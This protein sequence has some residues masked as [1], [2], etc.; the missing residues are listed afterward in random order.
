MIHRT[1][2]RGKKL[3]KGASRWDSGYIQPTGKWQKRL[4]SK[5]V[6]RSKEVANGNAHKKTW[7]PFEWS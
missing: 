6:R 5:K 1:I 2:R 3:P 4:A 7:G